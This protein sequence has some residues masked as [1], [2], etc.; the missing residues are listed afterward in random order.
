MKKI[1]EIFF[2][3]YEKEAIRFLIAGGINTLMGGILI[4]Y[5]FKLLL[6]NDAINI[7]GFALDIP[8]TLGYLIWF[9]FAYLLQVKLVFRTQCEL[10]RYLAYPLSQIPNYALNQ[11]FLWVFEGL[12]SLPSI[13]ALGLAALCPL[14]IM[15]VIV[16][17]IVKKP[18]DK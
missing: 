18:E 14:T 16:K 6:T 4:P 9:S 1:K 3:F 5:A 2:F 7:L 10:K 8:L 17:F 13:I 12:L 11:V 15:F